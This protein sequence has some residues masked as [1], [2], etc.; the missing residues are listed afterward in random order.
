MS[1]P[2]YDDIDPVRW[3]DALG[4]CGCGKPCTGTL[5]GPRNESYGRS[6]T[7]CANKRLAKAKAQRERIDRAKEPT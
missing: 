3:F 6:C 1:D 5:M 7:A 2:R 4:T